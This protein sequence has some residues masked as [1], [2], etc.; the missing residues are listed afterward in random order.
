MA[1]NIFLVVAIVIVLYQVY[2]SLKTGSKAIGQSLGDQALAVQ[3]GID[4]ARVNYIRTKATELWDNGVTNYIITRDYDEDMFI[5][6]I[7]Q[8]NTGAEYALLDQFFA[9]YHKDGW[10]VSQVVQASFNT[11][12]KN[13]IR[14][15]IYGFIKTS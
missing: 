2:K 1:I 4:A 12:E 5:N 11:D 9:E 3:V 10:T 14:R 6:V 7:N 15:D 13:R 8:M